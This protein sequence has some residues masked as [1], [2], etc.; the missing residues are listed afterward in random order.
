MSVQTI[1]PIEEMSA[2]ERIE[3]LESLW[4]AMSRRPE[5]NEPPAWHGEVLQAREKALANGTD[6]F[7][8]LAEAEARIRSRRR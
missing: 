6:Q 3:L 1:P 2:A 7:I 8:S 5:E 4:N